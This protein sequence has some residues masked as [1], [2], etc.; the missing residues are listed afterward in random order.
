MLKRILFFSIALT[1]ILVACA[2]AASSETET[3]AQPPAN[4]AQAAADCLV[5]TWQVDPQAYAAYM[6][7]IIGM[8][9]ITVTNIDKP[10]YYIFAGDETFSVWLDN[11]TISEELAQPSGTP[12]IMTFGLEAQV[13]GEYSSQEPATDAQHDG[14]L[15]LVSDVVN[16][17]IIVTSVT[18]NGEQIVTTGVTMNDLIDPGSYTAIGYDCRGNTLTLFPVIP[19]LAESSFVLS[20]DDTWTPPSP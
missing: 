5:G 15:K 8:S 3:S 20:R 1:L 10:F 4:A 14:W 2:P 7:T 13:M 9:D 18:L 16:S 19:D 12:N 17:R 11:V 6:T